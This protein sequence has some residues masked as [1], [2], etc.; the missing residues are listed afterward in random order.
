MTGNQKLI[1]QLRLTATKVDK[2]HVSA[3]GL[4]GAIDEAQSL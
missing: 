3:G 4:I 2:I 1:P